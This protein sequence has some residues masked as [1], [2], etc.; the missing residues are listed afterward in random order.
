MEATEEA[1]AVTRQTRSVPEPV[2]ADWPALQRSEM[3]GGAALIVGAVLLGLL[4]ADVAATVL[5]DKL[6][7]ADRCCPAVIVAVGWA[8][9][10]LPVLAICA[11]TLT[12]R[13]D[14]RTR[15][16]L[17]A[18]VAV[19]GLGLSGTWIDVPSAD[20]TPREVLVLGVRGAYAAVLFGG[21]LARC[22]DR[23][24]RLRTASLAVAQ[25]VVLAGMLVWTSGSEFSD[26][27]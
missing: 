22:F 5:L 7:V 6:C 8:L 2:D 19:L 4:T 24:V 20:G 27:L 3:L 11:L 10:G 23:S 25:V 17:L 9:P 16:A 13:R 12:G 14:W 1:G 18:S 15:R 26:A 21:I